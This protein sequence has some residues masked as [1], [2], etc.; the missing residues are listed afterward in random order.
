MESCFSIVGNAIHLLV[1]AVPGS[2]KTAIK[3]LHGGR[4]RIKIAAAPQDNKAN[5]EL[6]SF[7]AKTLGCAKKDVA[8][9]SG[10][11][12]RLKTLSLPLK[13]K[14]KLEGLISLP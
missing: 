7:L 9:I 12:S 1:H 2:A 4:L 6:C 3:D 8:L 11:K 13:A 14:E 5:E 10:E